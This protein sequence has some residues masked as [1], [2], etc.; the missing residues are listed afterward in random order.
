[1]QY[2]FTKLDEEN[3]IVIKHTN[4]YPQKIQ[5]A[6]EMTFQKPTD[7]EP[8]RVSVYFNTSTVVVTILH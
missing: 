8:E 5:L 7:N 1:M 4:H 2:L 3:D 6:V